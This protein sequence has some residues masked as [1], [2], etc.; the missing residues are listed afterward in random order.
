MPIY[1]DL[2]MAMRYCTVPIRAIVD[3]RLK[4]ALTEPAVRSLWPEIKRMVNL[5]HK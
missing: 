2:S 4:F 3:W 1:N 5:W